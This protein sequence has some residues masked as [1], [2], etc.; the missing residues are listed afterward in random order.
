MERSHCIIPAM[1]ALD[2]QIALWTQRLRTI[3]QTGLAFHP[4]VYDAERYDEMLKLAADMAATRSSLMRDEQ[5]S[6]KLYEK[7]RAEIQSG[8]AGYI[9]PKVGVGAIVFNKRDELLLIER[10]SHVWL[11]PTGWADIGYT[12]AQVAVKEV[13]E[14]TG[15][16]V[17]PERLIA[18]YDIRNLIEQDLD[19]HLYSIIFY[20]RLIGGDLVA[21]PHEVLEV[22]FFARDALP[23]PLGRGELGWIDLAW[24][25]HRGELTDTYFDPSV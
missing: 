7:W 24:R 19:Q 13:R 17:V 2:D 11:F 4:P 5:L 8:V 6:Q 15:L 3:A 20:C 1:P 21:R 18:V 9:T 14:E 25:A 23:A 12:P 16:A 10:P 22:G